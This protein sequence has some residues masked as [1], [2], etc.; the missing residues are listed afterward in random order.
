[1]VNDRVNVRLQRAPINPSLLSRQKIRGYMVHS[2]RSL[3][4]GR[5]KAMGIKKLDEDLR[6]GCK[7]CITVCPMDV[8]RFNEERE[9]AFSTYSTS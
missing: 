1:M 9:T 4:L 2:Q 8:I 7:I 5:A 6:P 3:P